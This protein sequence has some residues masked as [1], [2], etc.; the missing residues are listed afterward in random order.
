MPVW[1]E[2][3][4]SPL[5]FSGQ[6]RFHQP[7]RLAPAAEIACSSG[8][9]AI[10][11][12]PMRLDPV[13]IDANQ[14]ELALVNLVVNARDAMPDG[15]TITIAARTGDASNVKAASGSFVCVSV[16]DTGQGMDEATLARAV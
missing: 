3:G 14:L 15:G 16:T 12:F 10:T 13:L 7:Q 8:A 9:S 6:S 1:L 11:R 4:S 5:S 2:P